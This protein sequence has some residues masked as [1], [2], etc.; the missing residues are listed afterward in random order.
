[1]CDYIMVMSI[2]IGSLIRYTAV[3]DN[4]IAFGI[5]TEVHNHYNDGD[6][7][8]CVS[9]HWSDDNSTTREFVESVRAGRNWME[10]V[11]EGC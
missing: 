11:S 4:E 8:E 9:V 7:K 1:M 3:D 5:V 2:P 6:S 10:L